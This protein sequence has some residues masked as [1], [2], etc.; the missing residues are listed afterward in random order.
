MTTLALNL[1]PCIAEYV[2]VVT[3]I[4]EGVAVTLALTVVY[5]CSTSN[6]GKNKSSETVNV[7]GRVTL[8][9]I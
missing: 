5:K 8:Y 4:Q 7:G 9:H 3:Y 2:H 1:L 6:C